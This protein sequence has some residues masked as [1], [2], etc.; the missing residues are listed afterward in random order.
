MYISYILVNVLYLIHGA[1]VSRYST[2]LICITT[3]KTFGTIVN[4]THIIISI[5]D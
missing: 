3:N 5:S 2:L 4:I 1:N